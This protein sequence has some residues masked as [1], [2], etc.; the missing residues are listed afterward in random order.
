MHLPSIKKL[1]LWFGYYLFIRVIVLSAFFLICKKFSLDEAEAFFWGQKFQFGYSKHPPLSAWIVELWSTVTFNSGFLFHT[2]RHILVSLGMYSSYRLIKELITDEKLAIISAVMLEGVIYFNIV[3]R[4]ANANSVLFPIWPLIALYGY[5][6]SQDNNLKDWLIFCILSAVGLLG[7]YYTASLI[8]WCALFILYTKKGR[9][10]LMTLKPYLAVLVF[11]AIIFPHIYYVLTSNGG[12]IS[13]VMNRFSNDNVCGLVCRLKLTLEL[14]FQMIITTLL[15]LLTIFVVNFRV[16]EIEKPP[17]V[18]N[19]AK[20]FLIWICC[21][22]VCLFFGYQIIRGIRF[23]PNWISVDYLIFVPT[24]VVFIGINVKR[25][26]NG[27]IVLFFIAIFGTGVHATLNAID[28][29]YH[30]YKEISCNSI[31]KWHELMGDYPKYTSFWYLPI[32]AKMSCNAPKIE[33]IQD[34]SIPFVDIEKIKQYGFINIVGIK[35]DVS[36]RSDVALLIKNQKPFYSE[37]IECKKTV[38]PFY[39]PE[40]HPKIIEFYGPIN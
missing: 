27:L 9:Y 29:T 14:I 11:L 2:L 20:I 10:S 24:I 36:M 6:C 17:F 3:Q 13:Y 34:Q 32:H 18:S 7:K 28:G 23:H 35:N 25:L 38:L 37:I 19:H 33:I 8:L 40:C 15:V 22:Q 21:V 1:R 12:S 4:G 39:N 26:K 16:K 5:R 30:S 31:K